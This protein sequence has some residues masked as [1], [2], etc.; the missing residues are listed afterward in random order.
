MIDKYKKH[1]SI[2][3]RKLSYLM[4]IEKITEAKLLIRSHDV[5]S[6]LVIASMILESVSKGTSKDFNEAFVGLEEA[7]FGTPPDSKARGPISYALRL[8]GFNKDDLEDAVTEVVSK[9]SVKG[10]PVTEQSEAIKEA[11]HS[12]VI[13]GLTRG[14]YTDFYAWRGQVASSEVS[15]SSEEFIKPGDYF[16]GYND[17]WPTL[18]GKCYK[19]ISQTEI[20]AR[21]FTPRSKMGD[22][23]NFPISNINKV[24]SK[25]IF[26]TEFEALCDRYYSR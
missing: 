5:I 19:V 23:G 25:E 13:E 9:A 21:I 4:A 8:L 22:N 12:K 3:A 20:H 7:F 18:Y 2:L 17:N 15:N 14:E 16:K 26:E 24:I 6:K 1:A 11:I 10:L